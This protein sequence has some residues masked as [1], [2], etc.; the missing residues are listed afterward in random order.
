M[1]RYWLVALGAQASRLPFVV[2]VT[3]LL[4]ITSC[5]RPLPV[6]APGRSSTGAWHLAGQVRWA[7]SVKKTTLATTAEIA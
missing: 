5:W 1:V 3:L 6:I 7:E 2:L 4:L